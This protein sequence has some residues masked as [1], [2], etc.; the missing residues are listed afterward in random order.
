MSMRWLGDKATRR[1]KAELG[2]RVG[3]ALGHATAEMRALIGI[4][5]P[6]RSLPGEPPRIDSGDL[7]DSLFVDS[8]PAGLRARCGSTVAH[9]AY[10]EEGTDRMAARPWFLVSILSTADDIAR[11]LVP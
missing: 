7:I 3:P 6:P 11:E 5:G 8:D 2:R 1:L 9:A 10:T 4:Q